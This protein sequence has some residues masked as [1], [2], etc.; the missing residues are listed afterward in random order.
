MCLLLFAY[1]QHPRYP[2]ILLANR[3]EFYARPAAPA[4]LWENPSIVAG[5]DLEA[6]G[7][8][9]GA[10]AGGRIAAVTNVREPGRPEPENARSRG[11]IPTGFLAV[12]NT[13]MAFAQGLAGDR[14]RGFNTLLFDVRSEQAPICAGNRHTPFPMAVGVHGISNGAADAPWPKVL[15]G[16]SALAQ[17]VSALAED[18]PPSALLV[19]AMD[20]LQDRIQPPDTSLPDTGVGLALE[21]ALSPIFVQ[22]PSHIFGSDRGG[23]Y[24][25][26]ASTL[27]VAD[28]TGTVHFWEQSYL[29][30]ITNGPPR[31]FRLPAQH[32][33]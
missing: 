6:G 20:L 1:R 26:R 23:D 21:R 15:R 13:P 19:P 30:G 18:A 25:T 3:D 22:T 28:N 17:L 4:A 10:R 32:N 7:T 8:W 11:D 2:L 16:K 5:R 24:G 14:Y 29:N 9:L 31:H 12:D 27:V 33:P